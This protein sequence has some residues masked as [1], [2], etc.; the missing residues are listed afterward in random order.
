MT[1]NIIPGHIRFLGILYN[2]WNTYINNIYL[3][4]YNLR[5]LNI[6]FYLAMFPCNLTYQISLNKLT[7]LFYMKRSN[8]EI[9]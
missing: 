2:F 4:K 9:F 8:L 5:R 1:D 3:C 7:F 6:T